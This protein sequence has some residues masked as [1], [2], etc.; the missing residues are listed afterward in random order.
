MKAILEGDIIRSEDNNI[1]EE[2][3]QRIQVEQAWQEPGLLNRASRLRWPARPINPARLAGLAGLFGT[4][5][6]P[7]KLAEPAG[8]LGLA[9]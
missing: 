6:W 4:A 5:G 8:W 2:A 9:E 3:L 1:I 7:G